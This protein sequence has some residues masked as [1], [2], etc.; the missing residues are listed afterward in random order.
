MYNIA[1]SQ[2]YNCRWWSINLRAN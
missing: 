2:N 1:L